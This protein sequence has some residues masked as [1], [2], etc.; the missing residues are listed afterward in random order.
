MV[1]TNSTKAHVYGSLA[2]RLARR[3]VVWRIHDTMD[4]PDFSGSAS[5][6]LLGIG[7]RI[8]ARVLHGVRLH[9]APV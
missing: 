3:P 8:P 2:G 1:V 9:R 5:R 4:S 7:R 6:L